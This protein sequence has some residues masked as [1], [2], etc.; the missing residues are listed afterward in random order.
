MTILE[1]I[2]KARKSLRTLVAPLVVYV[3][4]SRWQQLHLELGTPWNQARLGVS[5]DL[6][7]TT[8]I[9]HDADWLSIGD[10]NQMYSVVLSAS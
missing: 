10:R 4:W 9:A 8:Y 2:H 1:E 7:G 6:S 3:P 5:T